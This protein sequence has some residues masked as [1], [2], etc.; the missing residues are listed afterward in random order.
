MLGDSRWGDVVAVAAGAAAVALTAG[1]W[2]RD[3][4]MAEV[5]LL[6]AAGV[7]I[8]RAMFI[9]ATVGIT[10]QGVYLSLGGAFIAAGSYVLEVR[11][12]RGRNGAP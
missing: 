6:L 8:T 1:W 5:G 4:R 11:D 2:A 10:A 7:Y 9:L 12:P 3:Q